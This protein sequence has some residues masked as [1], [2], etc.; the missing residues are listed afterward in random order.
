MYNLRSLINETSTNE[1]GLN[2]LI[3]NN[4]IART[5]KCAYCGNNMTIQKRGKTKLDHRLRC[6]RPC[7]RRFQY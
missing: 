2:F 4:L 6:L 3:E 5:Q 1:N 7:K